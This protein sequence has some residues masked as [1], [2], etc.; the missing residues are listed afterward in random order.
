MTRFPDV[1]A[2][3]WGWRDADFLT[4]V[5]WDASWDLLPRSGASDTKRW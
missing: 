3:V 2:T 4:I 5:F 1:Y